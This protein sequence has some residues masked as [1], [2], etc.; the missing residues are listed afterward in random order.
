MA[1]MAKI[2]GQQRDSSKLQGYL[3]FAFDQRE[4]EVNLHKA[5]TSPSNVSPASRVPF[6]KISTS[7]LLNSMVFI[8]YFES[9][10]LEK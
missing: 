6:M 3:N 10:I 7:C 5:T 1:H 9:D 4:I 8:K 2:R